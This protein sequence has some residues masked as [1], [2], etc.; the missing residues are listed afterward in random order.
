MG[1]LI[2]LIQVIIFYLTFTGQQLLSN[3]I[4]DHKISVLVN[5]EVITSYDIIQRTKMNAIVNGVTITPENKQAFI[6]SIVDELIGEKLKNEKFI[7]YNVNVTIDEIRN[8][9]NDFYSRKEISKEDLFKIFADNNI[10]YKNLEDY[11]ITEISWQKLI[12]GL[13]YRLTSASEIEIDNL[14]S[15]NPSINYEQAKNEIVQRQLD[16]KSNK[17][18]RDMFNEATIEFR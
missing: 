14:I 17:L 2:F 6:N 15:K 18:L 13:Y 11:F 16:L 1:K 3:E 5:D 9:E 10:L 4:N 7:E 8:Y 12:S